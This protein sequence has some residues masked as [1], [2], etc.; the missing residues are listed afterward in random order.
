ME[1]LFCAV[2]RLNEWCGRVVG[3]QILLIVAVIVYEVVA[4]Y[5]FNAPTLW[6]NETMIYV[7][8]MAYLLG[9]GYALL[10]RRHVSVDV[11][12][13]RL[14]AAARARCDAVTLVFF[15]LYLGA[16]IWAGS[17]WAWESMKIGETTGTPWNP[18][19]WPVKLAI[20]VAGALVLL[21][22]IAN[23]VRE[24]RAAGPG[25]QAGGNRA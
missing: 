18:P 7:T 22:G 15:L 11:V 9:G 2:D 16:L 4:R 21:Q 20:P 8:A 6:A 23:V 14:G 24:L 5:G 13:A 1:R 10:H 3:L 25:A 17:L 12:Y 19:I